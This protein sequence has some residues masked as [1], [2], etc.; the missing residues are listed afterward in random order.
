MQRKGFVLSAHIDM[1][2]RCFP[3]EPGI[4]TLDDPSYQ[5]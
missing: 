1:P 2:I 5:P 3:F 4:G